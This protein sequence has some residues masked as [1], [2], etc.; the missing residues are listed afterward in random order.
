M[1]NSAESHRAT[2]SF[3]P[4]QWK[5]LTSLSKRFGMH[6]KFSA[7]VPALIV[8]LEKTYSYFYNPSIL[9]RTIDNTDV[10]LLVLLIKT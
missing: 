7:W 9:S 5:G 4:L 1:D 10:M 2:L 3:Q 8:A 6:T